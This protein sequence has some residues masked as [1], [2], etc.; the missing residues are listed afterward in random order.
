[1]PQCR[2]LFI[3]LYHTDSGPQSPPHSPAF[4]NSLLTAFHC[5]LLLSNISPAENIERHGLLRAWVPPSR[6]WWA[7]PS[8]LCNNLD[9]QGP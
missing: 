3:W 1:M 8:T 5:P 6:L 4:P 9:L 7:V 2:Q